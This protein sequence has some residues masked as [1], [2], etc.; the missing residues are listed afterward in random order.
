MEPLN[1]WTE[2]FHER[3]YDIYRDYRENRP[4]HW[5]GEPLPSTR[6][7]WYLFRYADVSG[8]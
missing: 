8:S 5:E 4:V 3:L 6:G 2:G 1:P 7:S